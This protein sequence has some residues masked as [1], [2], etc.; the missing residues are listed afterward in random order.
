[1]G[2]WKFQFLLAL[3]AVV[4]FSRL[5]HKNADDADYEDE[6]GK[7]YKQKKSKGRK[8]VKMS[9][10]QK[11]DLEE[12][13]DYDEFVDKK[14]KGKKDK[15]LDKKIA[16]E[17]AKASK[18]KSKYDPEDYEGDESGEPS[19]DNF[20]SVTMKQIRDLHKRFDADGDGKA[21]LEEM[22]A[23]ADD[24]HKETL[25]K[26]VPDILK[27]LDHI[28]DGKL[29]LKEVLDD[30]EESETA[31]MMTQDELETVKELETLKFGVADADGDGKLDLDEVSSLFYPEP[32]SPV[33]QVSVREFIKKRDTD[34]DG[35]ISSAEFWTKE[36]QERLEEDYN[37]S[38]SNVSSS[39]MGEDIFKKLDKDGDGL[40]DAD[41]LMEWESGQFHLKESFKEL[42]DLADKDKDGHLSVREIEKA[43][44][45]I[46]QIEAQY[47][48]MHWMEHFEL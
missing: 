34:G 26:A 8:S 43:K 33:L 28:K 12:P 19:E 25:T 7:P 36:D 47:H 16:K 40:L 14:R 20:E 31:H 18:K 10:K 30:L 42:F 32:H 3:L 5:N 39:K 27:A 41:E 21:S 37:V 17:L 9:K 48:L 44:S 11:Y 29:S 45:D 15:K 24:V 1:M 22:L 2:L 38:D 23:F 13:E 35:K 4:V 6:L 46:A